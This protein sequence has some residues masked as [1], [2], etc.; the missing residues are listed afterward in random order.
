MIVAVA[1]VMRA[2]HRAARVTAAPAA[3]LTSLPH[4][5]C[6]KGNPNAPANASPETFA[7]PNT[8]ATHPNSSGGGGNWGGNWGAGGTGGKGQSGNA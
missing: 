7:N 3:A 2:S 8:F 1:V 5:N 4:E 6:D